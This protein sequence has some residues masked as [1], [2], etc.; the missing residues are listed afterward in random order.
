[1]NDHIN[2]PAIA[3]N[4]VF[5]NT[6]DRNVVNIAS[7]HCLQPLALSYRELAPARPITAHNIVDLIDVEKV[8]A[9]IKDEDNL[10]I[11]EKC[12]EVELAENNKKRQAVIEAIT[13]QIKEVKK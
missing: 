2:S 3:K 8:I 13:E 1:M 5:L 10:M 9:R 12:L 6:W 11:L 7:W 4:L